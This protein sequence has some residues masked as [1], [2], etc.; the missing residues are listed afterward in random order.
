G[1]PP[2]TGASVTRSNRDPSGY[3]AK[4][5]RI[6]LDSAR[7]TKLVIELIDDEP[8]WLAPTVK[9]M[10]QLL[11][12]SE[13]WDSD[14]ARPI[15]PQ[16]AADALT[17]LDA[18]MSPDTPPPIVSPTNRGGIQLEWHTRGIDL[19]VERKSPTC[20][21]VFHEDH[22]RGTEWEGELE[23]DLTRLASYL[24]ELAR[25]DQRP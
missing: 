24:A 4:L 2:A 20:V 9:T 16:A 13:D 6:E 8:D 18:T 23:T 7:G 22:R 3:D 11:H 15:D 14:G 25:R 1:E 10:A 5:R 21:Y 17:L 12:L 19:E